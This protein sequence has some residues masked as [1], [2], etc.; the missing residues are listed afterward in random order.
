M[1]FQDL[2]ESYKHHVDREN[3][4]IGSLFYDGVEYLPYVLVKNVFHKKLQKHF[5]YF[6]HDIPDDG[7]TI[8]ELLNFIDGDPSS[9]SNPA[10]IQTPKIKKKR[11]KNKSS[12]SITRQTQR[13]KSD[14]ISI[15][16]DGATSI[17]CSTSEGG[18]SDNKGSHKNQKNSD[19]W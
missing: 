5:F 19:I 18:T 7:R 10:P 17:E 13:E 1:K 11:R 8:D 15:S 16:E 2:I 14:S 9:S 4:E 12:A 6:H 3:L